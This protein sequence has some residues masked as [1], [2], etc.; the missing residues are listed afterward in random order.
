MMPASHQA[1]VEDIECKIAAR[2]YEVQDRSALIGRAASD[3]KLTDFTLAAWHRS[4]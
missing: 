4:T 1:P 2:I 3:L